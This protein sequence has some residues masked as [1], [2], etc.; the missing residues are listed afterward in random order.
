VAKI[1]PDNVLFDFD[2]LQ[3]SSKESSTVDLE[4]WHGYSDIAIIFKT[5]EED[6]NIYHTLL[7][8]MRMYVETYETSS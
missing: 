4:N 2:F 1:Y 7:E 6:I 3:R 5:R 8:A